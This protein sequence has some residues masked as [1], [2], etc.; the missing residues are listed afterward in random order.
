MRRCH[1]ESIYG[2]LEGCLQFLCAS[3]WFS[4][5]ILCWTWT[6]SRALLSDVLEI[7]SEIYGRTGLSF[8]ISRVVVGI[9]HDSSLIVKVTC[10]FLRN[11]LGIGF[12]SFLHM[13][14]LLCYRE[15]DTCARGF[16]ILSQ[17]KDCKN[18]HVTLTI[19]EG[20]WRKLAAIDINRPT[21][22]Q[23]IAEKRPVHPSIFER[24]SRTIIDVLTF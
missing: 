6:Y 11:F 15:D 10:I 3:E 16:Q 8:A 19:W 13:H 24:I 14:R 18:M 12:E 2:R 1:A 7:H 20:S 9:L 23:E 4:L 5:R 22:T 21:T 17:G